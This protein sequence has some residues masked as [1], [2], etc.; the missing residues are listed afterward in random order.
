MEPG[1]TMWLQAWVWGQ[2]QP[3][4]IGR[5]TPST[6]SPQGLKVELRPADPGCSSRTSSGD[7][8][9]A[10]WLREGRKHRPRSAPGSDTA[11]WGEGEVQGPPIPAGTPEPQR[12]KGQLE[13]S[14]ELV[15][16]ADLGAAST[17]TS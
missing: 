12:G 9:P 14:A 10:R 17:V 1:A 16:G 15:V 8:E 6:L 3:S 7:Q 2:Q 11:P 4:P 13:P 5:Y